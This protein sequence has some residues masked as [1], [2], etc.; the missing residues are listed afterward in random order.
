MTL[1]IDMTG[2]ILLEGGQTGL[3]LTQRRGGTV[4][5]TPEG[6]CSRYQEH[7]M[8]RVRY[9]TAHYNPSSGAAGL[10]HLENDIRALLVSLKK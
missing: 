4:V 9:S 10:T 6:L 2:R 8:P 5:Y 3:S 7:T 1:S